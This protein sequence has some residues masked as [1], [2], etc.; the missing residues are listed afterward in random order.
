L[1]ERSVLI[2]EV[3]ADPES[4][5]IRA[6]ALIAVD[7]RAPSAARGRYVM[8]VSGG[9]T[10][11]LM[12]LAFAKKDVA[13][14]AIHIFQVDEGVAPAGHADRNLTHVHTSLLESTPL[15]PEQI[16]AM[17]VDSPNLESAT[18]HY[19]RGRPHEH[20]LHGWTDGGT[21]RHLDLVETFLA[22]EYSQAE[23]RLRRLAKVAS[24][25]EQVPS[26]CL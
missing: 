7:A 19:A 4:V 2:V 11:W 5:A 26:K 21:V 17:P 1:I 25:E 10:P 8:A 9:H 12:L 22:A 23:R 18:E 3:L 6:A 14:K 20:Y 15:Q 24:L 16:Y 13:W